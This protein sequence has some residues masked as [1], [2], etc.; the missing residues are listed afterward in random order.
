M[1]ILS[2]GFQYAGQIFLVITKHQRHHS[3]LGEIFYCHRLLLCPPLSHHRQISCTICSNTDFFIHTNI[4]IQFH[5]GFQFLVQMFPFFC[6]IDLIFTLSFTFSRHNCGALW[7]QCVYLA[8]LN[9]FL[10]T[11]NSWVDFR[12][13]IFGSWPT[14]M[15]TN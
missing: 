8:S 2:I 12:M 5:L 1:A 14:E 13:F 4:V 7:K 6:Y 10:A 15:L 3:M 9:I 11:L